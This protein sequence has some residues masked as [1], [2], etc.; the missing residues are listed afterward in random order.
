MPK[1]DAIDQMSRVKQDVRAR[2]DAAVAAIVALCWDYRS[3]DFSFSDHLA[4]LRQVNKI[5]SEM[6]DGILSDSEKRAVKALAEAEL[7]DY[8][9]DAIEYAEGEINGEDTL[10]R[11][12]R[13][14]DHLR[15]LIAGWLAV[16]AF[17]GLSKSKM[18]QN[19][20][21]F[22]GNVSA[23]KDWRESGR[24]VPS[25]GKGFPIDI[26]T[27][28]TVIGQ[29]LIN[30]AFQYARIKSFQIAGAIG[31]RTIRQSS[32]ICP[33]CDEMC[34]RIWTFEDRIPLPYHPRCVCKAVPVYGEI[35]EPQEEKPKEKVKHLL[36]EK[37]KQRRKELQKE[38]SEKFKNVSVS[39]IYNIRITATGIKEYLNQPHELYF[40]KNEAVLE[41]DKVLHNAKYLGVNPSYS[42][43]NIR[44]SHIYESNYLGKPSWLI[45]REYTDGRIIFYSCSDNPKV[46]TA[47]KQRKDLE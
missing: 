33:L 35:E 10:F 3:P 37:Q 8:E 39:N 20:W 31:Y 18:I 21:T 9:D 40:K 7:Q 24:K 12:D 27:G 36:T 22:L 45:V 32:Y 46:A 47:L 42:A 17:V 25:W 29:D 38:A 41:I 15:D 26:L 11:L 14:A 1:D 28:M 5:L 6:S 23:S 30:R 34:E 44:Y 19:F 2:M 4:L 43:P 16:A 13:Q